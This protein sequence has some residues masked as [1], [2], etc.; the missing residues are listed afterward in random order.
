MWPQ[1]GAL[2]GAFAAFWFALA[3]A[4]GVACSDYGGDDTAK[5]EGLAACSGGSDAGLHKCVEQSRYVEDLTFIAKARPTGSPHHKAVRERIAKRLGELGYAVTEQKFGAGTNVLGEIKGSGKPDEVVIIGG[6]YDGVPNCAAADDNG[7]AVAGALEAA[8]VMAGLKPARTLIF[9]FWDEEERGL[10]GSRLHAHSLAAAGRKVVTVFDF[11]MIGFTNKTPGS[12]KVPVGMDLVFPEVAE[13]LKASNGAGTFIAVIAD[14]RN[15]EATAAFVDAA[16]ALG[17]SAPRLELDK[18][19]QVASATADL[20]RSDHASY[21]ARGYP[22]IM[23]TDTANFRN[24]HY[25]CDAGAD[26]VDR[27][28]HPFAIKVVQATVSAAITLLAG[29]K[30]K[31]VAAGKPP[32][33]LDKQD[34]AAGKKCTIAAD[35]GRL[36]AIC[37]DMPAVPVKE[38]ETCTRPDG[39]TGHDTCD[40]GLFCAFWELPKTDPIKRHCLKT[41]ATN[42]TCGQGR[43]CAVVGHRAYDSGTSAPTQGICTKR[44]DPAGKDCVAGTQCVGTKIATDD[45]RQRYSCD[46]AGDKKAGEACSPGSPNT[47][48]AGLTCTYGAQGDG[49]KCRTM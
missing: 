44:C 42:A 10:I 17:L 1:S 32:C 6:H 24:T 18:D 49:P 19:Y 16:K 20:R 3:I 8:R 45:L 39:K 35:S 15:K 34:C 48:A 28:D 36:A 38:H 14:D 5:A 13:A 29:D 12:Q 23:L 30:G 33:D 31:A 25:H 4:A 40:K 2:G 26:T 37:L 46:F 11:E 21:W 47:C 7:T 41:C 9:A 27:L 22:A 43:F